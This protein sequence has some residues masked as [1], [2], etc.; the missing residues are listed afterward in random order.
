MNAHAATHGQR[1]IPGE[2]GI[3]LLVFG[4]M[5]EF[6]LFFGVL[7]YGR[8][9]DPQLFAQSQALLNQNLG[10]VNTLLLLTSS[11]LVVLGVDAAHRGLRPRAARLIGW[12]GACGLAFVGIKCFEYGGKLLAGITPRTDEFFLYYF[13]FTGIHLAHLL[14]GLALLAGILRRLRRPAPAPNDLR[15]IESGATFWHLVDFLWIVLFPLLYII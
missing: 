12:A 6:S 8:A 3:W 11:L 2:L 10:L 13:V 1:R 5:F 15:A 14:V 4:E 9:H 7:L